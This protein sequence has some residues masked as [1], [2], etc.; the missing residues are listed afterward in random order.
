MSDT[1][2]PTAISAASVTTAPH[3]CPWW[4]GWL[5][6]SPLRRMREDPDRLL[7]P[8]VRPGMTVLE[9]G[10]GMGFF[11]VP[12]ARL[13]GATGRVVCVDVQPRMIAGLERRLRRAHLE[14]RV[15]TVTGTLDDPRLAGRRGTIDLVAAIHVVHEVP[16]PAAFLARIADFLRPGGRLLVVEPDGRVTGDDFAATLGHAAAAGLRALAP[17]GGWRGHVALLERPGA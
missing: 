10:P 5:L 6:A 9:P 17:P 13:V 16:D 8:L 4:V 11:S 14:A 15:E 12:L 7:G 3:V 2:D 1:H